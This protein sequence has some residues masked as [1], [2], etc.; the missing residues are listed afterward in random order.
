M[1]SKNL[2]QI[3]F[4]SA[5]AILMYLALFKFLLHFI[6]NANGAYG[7]FRDEFYYISCSDHLAF[8]YVDQPPFSIFMLAVSRFFLGDSLLAIRFLPALLGALTVFIAGK[9]TKELGGGMFAQ[10]TA[11]VCMIIAP[12]YLS[13]N[14]YYSMNSFDNFFWAISFYL[15]VLII[16]NDKKNL[17]YLLGLII[18]LGLMNKISILWLGAGLLAGLVLTKNRMLLKTKEP[19][20]A[21][22]IA[23]IIFVPHIIWQF[24][25]DFPTLEFIRNATQDKY[26]I[27]SPIDFLSSV[28]LLENPATVL[29]WI[30]GIYY[31]LFNEKGK[32]FRL[33][34]VLFL[35]V[36]IILLLNPASK[37][38]YLASAFPILFAGGSILIEKFFERKKILW[39]RFVVYFLLG[40]AIWVAPLAMPVLPV[41][42]YIKYADFFGMKPSTSEKKELNELPQFFAD[43]FGWD[44]MTK[45][46]AKV[47]NSLSPEEKQNSVIYCE[48]YG[49]AGA[50]NFLG[51][52]YD[53]APAIS[54][55]NNFYLW[56]PIRKNAKVVIVLTN[57][58]KSLE[59]SFNE[60]IPA[61]TIRTKYSMPYENNKPIWI[62]KHPKKPLAELWQHTKHYD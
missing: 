28:F 30:L 23:A 7:F 40:T 53:L 12:I 57:N 26:V 59:K 48:N 54:G 55:H 27:Q 19:W 45:T 43:M 13:F 38:E 2:R 58:G 36:L 10:T 60:V 1:N 32:Q 5:T 39:M 34:G 20:I 42:T 33:L 6:V 52:K 49:E 9:I 15:L 44:V 47:Y 18:G 37:A 35:T 51:K 31:F 46:V 11:A 16:K 17:W 22:L 8:G 61:D 4:L 14:T 21:F 56:G 29:I 25:N 50:I 3:N 41:E 24:A 62:C